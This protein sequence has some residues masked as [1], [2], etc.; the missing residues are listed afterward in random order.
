MGCLTGGTQK[1]EQWKILKE[2]VALLIAT[3]GRLIEMVH[4]NATNL[5]RC[6]ICVLDEADKLLQLGFEEQ[7]TSIV[8]QIRPDR[9]T[10]LFSATFHKSVKRLAKNLLFEPTYI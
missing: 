10:L 4:K 9:Q 6:T 2:G 3:P 8:K 5:R 1:H 7:I